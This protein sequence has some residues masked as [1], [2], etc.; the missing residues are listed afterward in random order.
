MSWCTEYNTWTAKTSFENYHSPHR[1]VKNPKK[2]QSPTVDRPFSRQLAPIIYWGPPKK[3]DRRGPSRVVFG[4]PR[5][6]EREQVIRIGLYIYN[7]LHSK[8]AFFIWAL[9]SRPPSFWSE[10]SRL[11]FYKKGRHNDWVSI[12][13]FRSG[14]WNFCC[15]DLAF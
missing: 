10:D 5:N 6:L 1:R 2:P 8:K 7:R 11:L 12:Y 3:F 14:N 9:L 4:F 13:S 15:L